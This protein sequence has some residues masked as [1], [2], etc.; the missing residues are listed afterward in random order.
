MNFYEAVETRRTIREFQPKPVEEEK[1][2]RVI[3]VGLKAPSHNHL[4]EWEFILV[5]EHEQRKRVVEEGAE[6]ENVTDEEQISRNLADLT[7]D[8]Q[9]QMYLTAMPVQKKKS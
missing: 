6:A 2:A 8:L 9:R 7:D 3:S 5:K 1:I 4:R